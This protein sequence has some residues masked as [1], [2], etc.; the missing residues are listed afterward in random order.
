MSYLTDCRRFCCTM[1]T[2]VGVFVAGT[3]AAQAQIAE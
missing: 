3:A 2:G 1:L